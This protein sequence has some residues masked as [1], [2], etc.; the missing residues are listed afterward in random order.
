MPSIG[1][2]AYFSAYVNPDLAFQHGSYAIRVTSLGD[3]PLTRDQV[4][5]LAQAILAKLK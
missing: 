4:E 3:S 2:Q 1:D 5:A